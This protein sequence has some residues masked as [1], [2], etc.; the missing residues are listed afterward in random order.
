M[1]C[2]LVA[3]HTAELIGSLKMVVTLALNWQAWRL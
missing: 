3:Q 1:T 2:L